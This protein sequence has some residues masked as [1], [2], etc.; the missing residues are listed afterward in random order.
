MSA[1][2]PGATIGIIGGGQLARMM[3]LEARRMGYRVGILAPSADDPA[4][5][6]ADLWIPG[7]INDADAGERLAKSVD[8]V[9][10]DSEHVPA[11]LLAYLELICPVRPSS[12]VLRTP[13]WRTS[14]GRRTRSPGTT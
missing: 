6:L 11:S 9:T 12:R 14:R 1:L 13:S 8:V 4:V 7:A 5:P 2:L 10:V 3:T